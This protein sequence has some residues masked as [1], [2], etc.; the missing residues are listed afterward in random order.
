MQAEHIT[1]IVVD[2]RLFLFCTVDVSFYLVKIENNQCS[3]LKEYKSDVVLFVCFLLIIESYFP[4]KPSVVV[5]LSH[6]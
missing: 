3:L 6:V 5:F 4:S 2:T 1:I